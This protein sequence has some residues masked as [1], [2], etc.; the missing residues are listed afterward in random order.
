MLK[1][2]A[3]YK[4][5][6]LDNPHN[7]V[8][9]INQLPEKY[10]ISGTLIIANEGINATIAGAELEIDAFLVALQLL[11]GSLQPKYSFCEQAPFHRFKVKLKNEIVTFGDSS[12]N[13]NKQVGTYVPPNQWNDLIE[14]DEVLLVDTRN[15]YETKIGYFKGSEDPKINN[16]LEFKTYLDQRIKTEPIEKIAMYCTG[17][18]RC[19]KSTSY[20]LK[21]GIKAVYHLEGGILN[22]FDKIAQQDSLWEGECFVFD[23]RV[24]V[25]QNLMRG[26][27]LLCHA[28]G[29]PISVVEQQHPHYEVGVSCIACFE[30][31]TAT[32]KNDFRERVKQMK[33][34]EHS[35]QKHIGADMQTLR[36]QSAE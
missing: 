36:K 11:I 32:R 23:H 3:F 12:I 34:A 9:K 28:C 15:Q 2:A 26:D 7:I 10:S 29:D 24:S 16:F 5:T 1:V 27:Y 19:E 30:H 31:T 35:N 6:P 20:A 13:P 14:Q 8:D 21:K 25:N 17:G 33:L 4:F 18:I 22:Y